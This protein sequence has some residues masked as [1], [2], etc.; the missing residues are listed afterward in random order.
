VPGEARAP[1]L[2]ATPDAADRWRLIAEAGAL[3]NRLHAAGHWHGG[4]QIRNFS[5]ASGQPGL[6]DFEDHDLPGMTLAEKQARDLLLF[7]YSLVRYDRDSVEPQL[8]RIAA[9]TLSESDVEQEMR[10]LIG[11]GWAEYIGT[12]RHSVTRF[13]V[14]IHASLIRC[15]SKTRK[16][17]WRTIEEL[18][19]IP[20][21]SPQRRVLRLL[22]SVL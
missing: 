17:R 11:P 13:R 7:L 3:L 9:T 2:N 15:G 20:M 21:P 5:Y 18:D 14:T 12:V 1:R 19:T 8:P 16:L 6:L 4:A 10:K 22:A